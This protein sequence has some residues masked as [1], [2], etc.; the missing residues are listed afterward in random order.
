[1]SSVIQESSE[2][3][4]LEQRQEIIAYW[5]D[6]K[7]TADNKVNI[8]VDAYTKYKIMINSLKNLIREFQESGDYDIFFTN[9]IQKKNKYLDN[10]KWNLQTALSSQLHYKLQLEMIESMWDFVTVAEML[11]FNT[12]KLIDISNNDPYREDGDINNVEKS[13]QFWR[14][15][16]R[17]II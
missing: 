7:L 10:L 13:I 3:A 17:K 16:L 14:D 8:A 6:K 11:D 5:K 15:E 2:I 1:M 12:K 4:N 9:V